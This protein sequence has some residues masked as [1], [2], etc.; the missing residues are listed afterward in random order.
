MSMT[1]LAHIYRADSMSGEQ[2]YG[3]LNMTTVC[4]L[5]S[6]AKKDNLGNTHDSYRSAL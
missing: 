5:A 6:F 2:P 4:A 1:R 3:N